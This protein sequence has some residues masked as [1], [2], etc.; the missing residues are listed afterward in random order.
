MVISCKR[1]KF[2]LNIDAFWVLQV[3]VLQLVEQGKIAFETPVGDIIPEIANPIVLEDITKKSSSYKPA[4]TKITLK[5]LLTHTSGLVYG[6]P[7]AA[8]MSKAYGEDT[9]V[10]QFFKL[11]QVSPLHGNVKEATVINII[12]GRLSVC[13]TEVR[14]R[15][16][17]LV[18]FYIEFPL[19]LVIPS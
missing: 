12:L 14:T 7:P 15:D 4:V 5:H 9:S 19:L 6:E 3:A 1:F 13:S 8:Y 17:L 2:R 16:R 10:S 11:I 18:L